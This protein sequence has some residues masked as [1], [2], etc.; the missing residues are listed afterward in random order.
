MRGPGRKGCLFSIPPSAPFAH[1]LVRA[2]VDGT[3]IES[4]RPIEDPLS[5]STATLYLPTRRAART[6]PAVFQEVFGGRPVLLPAIRPLGD[7]D[8]IE[9]FLRAEPD[10]EPLPPPLP[11]LERRLALTRLVMAWK[12]ALR[13]DVLRLKPDDPLG[14]PASA[15]DAAWLAADL[16]ALM[17]EVETEEVDWSQLVG[18]VPDDY[19]RYWQITLDF[20]SIV[21]DAW[22]AYLAER[23]AMDPKARRS[24]LIRREAERL[25]RAP[26]AGPVI[27]AGSTGSVPATAE[28]LQVVAG[29][30]NGAI[31]L[32]A[33]DMELDDASWTAL[34]GPLPSRIGA[35]G[36]PAGV[37]ETP[38]VPGHPQYGLKLLLDRLGLGRDRVAPLGGPETADLAL[39]DRIVSEALRPAETSDAWTGFLERTPLAA[40]RAA[41]SDVALLSARNEVEEALAVAVVLR[42]AV[43]R[44]ETAALVSPD[45]MLARRVA[46]DLGRWGIAVDDSAGRP[47]DQTPPAILAGLAARLALEGCAPIDLLSLLKHP[48]ARLGLTAREI[49]AAARALERGVLR[50]PRPLPGTKGLVLAVVAARDAAES[51]HTPRWRKLY[52]ADWVAV[53]DLVDRLAHALEPLEALA[54][55]KDA[56]PVETLAAA[57]AEVLYRLAV[58]EA[59]TDAELYSG[60]TGD[61]L[62]L[63]LAGLLEAGGAGLCIVPA[64]W[65]SVFAALMSG[66][67]VRRRLPGDPRIQI[68]GPME[69]RLLRPDLVVLGGLNEG[70]WP[71]R[72]RNDPWLNRPMK[73]DL[74]LDPPERRIGAAAHDFAQGLGARRVVLA[75]AE[76]ADGAPT[77]ASRWLQRLV[78]L[79][80]PEIEAEMTARG[81][82]YLRLAGLLDRP[83][84][85]VRPA[86]RPEPRPAL[87]A[88]PKRLSVTE[89]E[90]LVRDPYA[91]FAR[92]ILGLEPVDPVGGVPGAADKGTLIHDA[93]ARFLTDW[94]GPYDDSAVRRLVEIGETM[95]SPL[96]AF[97]AIRALWWPRFERIARGFV[98]FEAA[99][100]AG[101]RERFL[102]IGG[103]VDLALPGIEFRLTGRADRIDLLDDGTYA[104]IDYKTGQVPSGNQVATLLAP[105]LPLEAAMIRR[106]GFADVPAGRPVSDLL[107]IQLKGA[108][109][110]LKVETRAPRDGSVEDLAEEAWKRLEA[111]VAAYADPARG[112][113]SRARVLQERAMDG[114]YDHLARVREWS[115]GSEEGE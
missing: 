68:L 27:V 13:R 85:P 77:V 103:G 36:R 10:G 32:P 81:R 14:L 67:A 41:L 21:R 76:R 79:V 47:L 54:E 7:V 15:A 43:E 56:L 52:D 78:T 16:L 65:P 73:R 53:A 45:R 105:Q 71:Q 28:L 62:A 1:T 90:R 74:G 109:E 80:G 61:A 31:V 40:R 39:R 5:L 19:A 34:G 11:A 2:L 20:L 44:G 101:L 110:A 38:S 107:Y 60:E 102:E 3:L 111:L 6:L 104:V 95:F 89:I 46:E 51:D 112:Y 23:G 94:D 99:R 70:V 106:G 55:A 96:D 4:F 59:G 49:R 57:H 63:F 17:D 98:A 58:D 86:S 83:E 114:P 42:E 92:R 12:G 113:L 8:E 97:P 26:P 82:T 84:G 88:R 100:A 66:T 37:A 108:R 69:A 30:P 18:L 72:T 93:L 24:A 75:R 9:Q 35:I 115:V 64:E 22:P 29:L 91:I 25:R 33:L 50:G 87:P 48:L